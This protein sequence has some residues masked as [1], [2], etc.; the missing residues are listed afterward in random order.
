MNITKHVVDLINNKADKADLKTYGFYANGQGGGQ[1]RF[2][3]NSNVG[4]SEWCVLNSSFL[5]KNFTVARDSLSCFDKVTGVFTAQKKGFHVFKV[6]LYLQKHTSGDEY[7]FLQFGLNGNNGIEGATPLAMY[8]KD[9]SNSYVDT[10][11]LSATIHL[12]V[13]DQVSLRMFYSKNDA[14]SFYND[15]IQFSGVFIG[16]NS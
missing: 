13:G 6:T 4:D 10:P 15:H 14:F 1:W 9:V 5:G 11:Q 7:C 3:S 2:A 8:G 12:S 16:E